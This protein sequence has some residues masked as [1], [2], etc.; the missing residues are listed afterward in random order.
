MDINWVQILVTV[1]G[2]ALTAVMFCLIVILRTSW[3][4]CKW[5]VRALTVPLIWALAA[6]VLAPT[7]G[8]YATVTYTVISLVWAASMIGGCFVIKDL[9]NPFGDLGRSLFDH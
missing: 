4:D 2:V 5:Y 1:N 8:E 7:W 9:P 3:K 6:G